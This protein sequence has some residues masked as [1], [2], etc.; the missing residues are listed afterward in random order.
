MVRQLQDKR[1]SYAY[2]NEGTIEKYRIYDTGGS[3]TA[4]KNEDDYILI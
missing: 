4:I 1:R 3:W 2:F